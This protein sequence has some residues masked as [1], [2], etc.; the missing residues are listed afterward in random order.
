[1][2]HQMFIFFSMGGADLLIYLL[3]A[4]STHIRLS[5]RGATIPIVSTN[6]AE[7]HLTRLPA[8]STGS[9]AA[10]LHH[11]GC[12][13]PSCIAGQSAP[14]AALRFDR[15]QAYPSI[16]ALGTAKLVSRGPFCRANTCSSV[17]TCLSWR[18]T[19]HLKG[20]DNKK[21]CSSV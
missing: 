3:R 1:M 9:S 19:T 14:L 6:L 8:H 15:A 12:R 5:T 18:R 17:Q 11:L 16:A 2:S 4:K 21:L 7:H 10:G 13:W 20:F